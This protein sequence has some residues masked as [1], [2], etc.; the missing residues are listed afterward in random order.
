MV[1]SDR[2]QSLM[3]I[4]RPF[5]AQV[6]AIFYA[7]LRTILHIVIPS[8]RSK[9]SLLLITH[10]SFLL[11]RTLLSLYV[12][13]L[14]GRIVSALVRQRGRDFLMGILKWLVVAIPATY[15]NSMISYLQSKLALAYRSRL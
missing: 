15:T 12:A 6:D 9:E 2:D 8:W 4:P 1:P 5:P 11:F 7:K 14:D 10:T 3:P 13:D